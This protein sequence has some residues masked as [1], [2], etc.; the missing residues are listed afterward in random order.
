MKIPFIFAI[1]LTLTYF[2]LVQ[3]QKLKKGAKK[4]AKHDSDNDDLIVRVEEE[5]I[6]TTMSVWAL[7]PVGNWCSIIGEMK[8]YELL[9]YL[10]TYVRVFMCLQDAQ[11]DTALRGFV[12]RES[13]RLVCTKWLNSVELLKITE[14]LFE[15][16]IDERFGERVRASLSPLTELDEAEYEVLS[17]VFDHRHIVEFITLFYRDIIRISDTY[18]KYHCH[19]ENLK[20]FLCTWLEICDELPPYFFKRI[21]SSKTNLLNFQCQMFELFNQYR[22]CANSHEP[23]DIAKVPEIQKKI[24]ELGIKGEVRAAGSGGNWLFFIIIV[25]IMVVILSIVGSILY[26]R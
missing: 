25:L 8:R 26:F 6:K 3:G 19:V 18:E 17:L 11:Q 16:R 4:K 1:I 2:F 23:K 13:I 21:I 7:F 15:E 24:V 9:D 14:N 22:A 20:K 5:K 12:I 10:W